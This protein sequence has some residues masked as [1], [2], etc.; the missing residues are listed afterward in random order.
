VVGVIDRDIQLGTLYVDGSQISIYATRPSITSVDSISNANDATIGILNSTKS[1]D[2][3]PG[4]IDDV[5]TYNSVL[6]P[7]EI[8][9]LYNMGW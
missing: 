2:P 7:N 6:S 9:Q 1:S 8:K 5:R 3:F 4:F